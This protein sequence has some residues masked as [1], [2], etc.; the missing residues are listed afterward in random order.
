MKVLMRVAATCVVAVMGAGAATAQMAYDPTWIRPTAAYGYVDQPAAEAPCAAAEDECLD[1]ACACDGCGKWIATVDAIALNRYHGQ[2]RTLATTAS[3]APLLTL[4]SMTFDYEINPRASLIRKDVHNGW[5]LE[6]GYFGIDNWH[7]QASLVN[8]NSVVFTTP[9]LT[10]AAAPPQGEDFFYNARLYSAEVN[11][12]K[13]LDYNLTFLAG[14]RWFELQE[15]F[16][17]QRVGGAP[18]SIFWHSQTMNH[19]YGF[20]LG[21]ER[22]LWAG[23]QGRLRLDGLIKAGIYDNHCEQ[24]SASPFVSAQE[25]VAAQDALAFQGEV[26]LTVSYQLSSHWAV[27]SGYQAMWMESVALAPAQAAVTNIRTQTATV[28]ASGGFLA[29]GGFFGLEACY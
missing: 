14:F 24:R 7:S 11:L 10:V 1:D 16:T 2:P 9:E 17:G 13:Q 28:D 18:E 3:G 27:R 5:D 12:R 25:V 15:G 26:F 23:Q 8:A 20:Q 6:L 29:Q 22:M 19:L 21:A 4:N